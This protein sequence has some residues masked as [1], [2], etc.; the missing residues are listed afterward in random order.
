MY[1]AMTPDMLKK[2]QQAGPGQQLGQDI[3]SGILQEFGFDGSVFKDPTSFGAFKFLKS[4]MGVLSNFMK[5]GQQGQPQGGDGASLPNFTSLIPGLNISQPNMP[6]MPSTNVRMP[7]GPF[8]PPTGPPPGPVINGD[9]RPINVSPN[10]DPSAILAPV[11]AQQN[12][13]NASTFTNSGGFPP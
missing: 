9:Y 1:V 12:S 4:G 10:V 5:G 8:G 3:F 11:Q 7:D 2:Q 6:G 13:Y